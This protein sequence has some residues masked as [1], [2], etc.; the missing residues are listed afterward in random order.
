M[1]LV[2]FSQMVASIP[3]EDTSAEEIGHICD[4]VGEP[5][6][7]FNDDGLEFLIWDELD[8]YSFELLREMSDD[9]FW[10]LVY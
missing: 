2:P 5:S 4:Q 7:R 10:R 1:S 3:M 9:L 8:Q 6:D